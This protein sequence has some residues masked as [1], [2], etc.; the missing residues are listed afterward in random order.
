MIPK[1]HLTT[2]EP[3][4]RQCGGSSDS[5]QF[6]GRRSDRRQDYCRALAYEVVARG[7][8]LSIGLRASS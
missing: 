7:E 4:T 8:M 2:I 5:D 3:S 1:S 6:R